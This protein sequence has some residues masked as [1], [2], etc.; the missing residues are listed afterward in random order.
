MPIQLVS[1][2][3][4]R[5]VVGLHISAELST[6]PNVIMNF[7]CDGKT[8]QRIIVV[9]N[10]TVE[11]QLDWYSNCAEVS[12]EHVP[13]SGQHMLIRYKFQEM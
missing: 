9:A 12:F 5:K 1:D 10:V 8:Y 7:G 3:E 13:R 6:G 4:R 11:R 2:T